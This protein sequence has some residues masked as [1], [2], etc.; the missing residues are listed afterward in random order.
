M[1]LRK[2]KTTNS[3]WKRRIPTTTFSNDDQ[4]Q[5]Q[6]KIEIANT[7]MTATKDN[8]EITT[9]MNNNEQ[10][11]TITTATNNDEQPVQRHKRLQKSN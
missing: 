4:R 9:L 10:K 5:L 3:D 8:K 1:Q 6:N 11:S 2:T 7:M